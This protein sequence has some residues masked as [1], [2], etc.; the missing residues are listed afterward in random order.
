MDPVRIGVVGTGR[1]GSTLGRRWA[2]AG[3]AVRFGT[4]DPGRS[5]VRDLVAGIDG[6]VEAVEIEAA[7]EADVLV[8]AIPVGAVEPTLSGLGFSGVLVDPTNSYPEP[9]PEPGS[10]RV[11]RLAPDARVVKAFNTVGAEVMAD[12]AFDG[13][14]A[15]MPL[16]GDDPDAKGL[17]ADLTRDLGFEP[18]DVGD[19]SAAVHLENLARLWIHLAVSTGNREFAFVHTAR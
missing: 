6:E 7:A 3:H 16:A 17:V 11:A 4:R 1:V 5:D 8:L 15:T 18:L 19:R 12:P 2:E 10:E 13:V 14:A 9:G